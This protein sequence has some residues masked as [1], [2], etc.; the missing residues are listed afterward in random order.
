MT[1]RATG[2]F[3]VTLA[4]LD[5]SAGDPGLG[6]MSL[7]KAFHGDLEATSKGEMLTAGTAVNGSAAYVAI[8]RI[9]GTLQGKA[10]SF[11]AHHTGV[12]TRGAPSL[13]V[14][15]VPDSGTG[16]LTGIA[17]TIGIRIVDG[18]HFYDLDYSL[19]GASG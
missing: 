3:D 5:H 11:A 12:M 6:R 17:G 15:I 8:E 13:T 10:G 16:A 18:K 2:A 4:A 1:I 19:P 14:T 7:D 9:T